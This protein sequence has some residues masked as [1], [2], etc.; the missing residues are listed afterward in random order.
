[1]KTPGRNGRRVTGL[2]VRERLIIGASGPTA[3]GP[4]VHC[5]RRE[6][7]MAVSECL[8]CEHGDGLVAG[9]GGAVMRCAHPAAARPPS[10]SAL[11]KGR[12]VPSDAERTPLTA[13]MSGAV[14]C[15]RPDLGAEAL[16]FLLTQERISGAPVVDDDG[17]PIGV[18]SKSD[19]VELALGAIEDATVADIMMPVAFTLAEGASV[20]QAAAIMAYEDVHRIPVVSSDGVVIGLVSSLDIVRWLARHDGF[21]VPDRNDP[22][23]PDES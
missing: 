11:L 7:S 10:L 8:A 20:S 19:L 6:R 5:E 16:S 14:I 17:R 2:R 23:A 9:S 15:V 18:V 1:V 13:I 12:R 21:L 4:T 3:I 22:I